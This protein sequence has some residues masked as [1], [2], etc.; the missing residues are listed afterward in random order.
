MFDWKKN[1]LLL[2]QKEVLLKHPDVLKVTAV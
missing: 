2:M 1:V